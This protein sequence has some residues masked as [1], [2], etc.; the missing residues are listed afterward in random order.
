[1][2]KIRE[3][4]TVQRR[5]CYLALGVGVE[6]ERDVLGM[7][8]QETEGARVLDAATQAARRQRHPDRSA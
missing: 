4:G 2:L 7:W 8:F 3:G 1:L 5:P 6:G